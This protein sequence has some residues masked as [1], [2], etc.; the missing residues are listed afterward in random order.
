MPPNRQVGLPS[1]ATLC[2]PGSAQNPGGSGRAGRPFF[3]PPVQ[4]TRLPPCGPPA[5]MAVGPPGLL[6]AG[7]LLAAAMLLG[8][9]V[10]L[11]A[12]E[13]LLQGLHQVD[14]GGLFLA[15]GGGD[16]LA[17]CARF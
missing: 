5:L 8:G 2:L 4:S 15:V 16:L 17:G 13:A 9:A 12:V 14:D 11:G 7:S 3:W 6:G 10:L 1:R